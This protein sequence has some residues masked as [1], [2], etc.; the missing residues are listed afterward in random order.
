MVISDME[1]THRQ[2]E[3]VDRAL[4][5]AAQSGIQS[6]TIK[7]LSS[8]IGVTEPAIYRHFKNKSEIVKSMI[9]SFD[10]AVPVET[11]ALS[12]WPAVRAFIVARF[13]QVIAK[14]DLAKVMFAEELFM[15]DA[16]FADLMFAMM[17]KHKDII[18]KELQLAQANGGMRADLA[19]DMLFRI[20]MGPVR[21]LVKQWGM[22]NAAFDLRRKGAELLDSLEKILK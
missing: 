7:N 20:I 16:E 11:D 17:H 10:L 5:L 14:P 13:E 1:L 18:G 19:A 3:I 2:Q 21:L 8:A 15:A 12:G 4:H 22:S 9:E 6:L